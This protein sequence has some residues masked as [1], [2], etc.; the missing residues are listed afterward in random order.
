MRALGD[1]ELKVYGIFG[2]PLKHTVS[3]AM[4]NKAFDH[5]RLKS[6]YFAF[7]RTP[8]QFRSLMRNLKSLLLDGFNVTVPYKWVVI[9]DLKRRNLDQ[10]ASRVDAVNTVKKQG[11]KWVGY[12]TDVYGF[13]ASLKKEG[14]FDPRGKR[15]LVLGA[16][17]A[18]SAV[19]YG[20][21]KSGAHTIRIMN[22]ER[23]KKRRKK[24]RRRFERFFTRVLFQDYSLSL[25]NLKK[26]LDGVDLVV[27]AT[28]TGVKE[29]KFKTKPLIPER[30]IPRAEKEKRLLFFDLVYHRP[31]PFLKAAKKRGH[32]VLDGKGM[33]L[34]QG[35]KAFEIWTGRKAPLAEMRKALRDALPHR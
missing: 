32:R 26:A 25:E 1:T 31:T 21:C 17:G 33:L 14:K 22:R 34:Y 7:E 35:A 5:Y 11:S 30:L 3:P 9:K 13:L 6:I 29:A 4:Q 27:N 19:V 18:A 8:A 16:G 12:N 15:V 28:S 20:L 10:E 24:I 23:Y 2:H